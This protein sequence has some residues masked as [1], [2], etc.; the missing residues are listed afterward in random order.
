M[1]GFRITLGGLFLMFVATPM[2]M[3]VIWATGVTQAIFGDQFLAG[4]HDTVIVEIPGLVDD[5]WLAAQ[6]PGAVADPNAKAWVDAIA[7]TG[8]SPRQFLEA[9]GIFHWLK[10]ELGGTIDAV[11][12]TL[13]GQRQP[14]TVFLDLEPLKSALASKEA[15]LY[16]QA[17]LNELP[18]CDATQRTQWK[19]LALHNKK[20]DLPACNPGPKIPAGAVDLVMLRATDIPDR[21]PV[22][23]NARLPSGADTLSVAGKLVCFAFIAPILCLLLGGALVGVSRPAFLGWTGATL[24]IGGGIPLLTTS[25]VQELVSQ[26]M[27][28]DPGRWT[29]LSKT[30]F[31]TSKASHAL[32]LR[33]ADV[34]DAVVGQLFAPVETIAMVVTGIG[35]VLVVMAFLAPGKQS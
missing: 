20:E 17:I 10:E 19:A 12:E 21:V 25:F 24:L 3:A 1:S 35:L 11:G 8:Q 23:E 30:P 32:S 18:L 28:M 5:A 16:F 26:A 15:R 22:F 6:E 14:E 9:M 31:W 2:F 7:R 4:I 13:R 34:F 33:I 27:R 29:T